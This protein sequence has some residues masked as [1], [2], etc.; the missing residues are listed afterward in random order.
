MRD[1]KFWVGEFGKT[2]QGRSGYAKQR[3]FFIWPKEFVDKV[4][5]LCVLVGSDSQWITSSI[6]KKSD[7]GKYFGQ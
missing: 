2:F 4:V 1:K 3:Y 7:K 5:P 6:L